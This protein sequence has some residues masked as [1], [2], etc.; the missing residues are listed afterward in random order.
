MIHAFVDKQEKNFPRE[1]VPSDRKDSDKQLKVIKAILDQ[2]YDQQPLL[3][4]TKVGIKDMLRKRVG[5]PGS[6]QLNGFLEDAVNRWK[7]LQDKCKERRAM[8]DELNGFLED[9]VNRWKSLQDK[10]KE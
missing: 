1:G 5:A 4:E 3:D 9:A 7:S 10:C 6:E 8:L 2:M